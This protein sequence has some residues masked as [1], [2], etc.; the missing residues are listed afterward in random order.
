MSEGAVTPGEG[1]RLRHVDLPG[2]AADHGPGAVVDG[3]GARH[4]RFVW[5]LCDYAMRSTRSSVGR[6]TIRCSLY[7]GHARRVVRC[8]LRAVA[9]ESY[10]VA[11]PVGCGL[12]GRGGCGVGGR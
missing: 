10:A 1:T 11:A 5:P 7:A 4:P 9:E 6:S 8:C 3:T 2:T 12:A